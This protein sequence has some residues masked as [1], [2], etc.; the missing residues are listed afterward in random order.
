MAPFNQ[1][2]GQDDDLTEADTLALRVGMS[3]AAS[4]CMELS[5]ES[6]GFAKQLDEVLVLAKLCLFGQQFEPARVALVTYL[7]QTQPTRREDALLLLVRAFLGLGNT[8]SAEAQILSLFSDYPYDAQIHLAAKK[9]IG[10]SEGLGADLDQAASELCARQADFVLPLLE[11][12]KALPGKDDDISASTL[13]VDA[14]RCAILN[15]ERGGSSANGAWEKLREIVRLPAWQNSADLLPMKEA[16][17]QAEMV[18]RATPLHALRCGHSISSSIRRG[19]ACWMD[20]L[21]TTLR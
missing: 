21:P 2:R 6:Q 19:S 8:Y 1:A 13:Y 11:R 15:R 16:L 5:A 4:R 20:W 14:L 12:G 18:G 7:A 3:E 9:V 10:A 17:A